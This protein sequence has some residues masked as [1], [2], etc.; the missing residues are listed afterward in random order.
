M[1]SET[2]AAVLERATATD[3]R[4]RQEATFNGTAPLSP[5]MVAI[6]TNRYYKLSEVSE[7]TRFTVRTLRAMIAR[8]D[9]HAVR[10]GRDYRVD[11]DELA[12]FVAARIAAPVPEPHRPGA[13]M[14]QA[15]TARRSDRDQ[16]EGGA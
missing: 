13:S 12:R 16:D 3:A 1:L 7:I 6:D 9:L 14:D 15:R 5:V 11:G 8:G 2:A 4:M 10:F